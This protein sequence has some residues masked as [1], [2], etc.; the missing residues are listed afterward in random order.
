VMVGPMNST[1]QNTIQQ[2][3]QCAGKDCPHQGI[4]HL[5]IRY[6]NKFGWFC[7]SCKRNLIAENLVIDDNARE[8]NV[9]RPPEEYLPKQ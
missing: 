9:F 1:N 5:K 8:V 7:D 3:K 2:Y 6:I 4:N